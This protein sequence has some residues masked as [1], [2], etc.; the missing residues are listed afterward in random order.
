MT[1]AT[2][3]GAIAIGRNEGARLERCLDSLVGVADVV[4]YVDS[5]STDGS[6]ERAR[7]R[8]VHVVE[9]PKGT[10]FTAGR[11]RNLG[12]ET[13]RA[14]AP[15]LAFVQFVDGDCEVVPGWLG[16]AKAH[17][18][19][20]PEVAVVCG[21]RRE[22]APEATPYNRIT[23]MEWNTPIGER[24]D[25]GGDALFRAGV[26]AAAGGFD[27]NLIAGEEPELCLRIRREGHRIHRID[28]DMTLHDADLRYFG[29]WWR[30]QVRS[31]HA[32]VES[33]HLHGGSEDRFF[34]RNLVS[35]GAWALAPPALALLGVLFFGWP[36]L[37]PLGLYAV[38]AARVFRARRRLE[39]PA[40]HAAL[41][42]ASVVVGK[43]AEFQGTVTYAWNR[44]VRG[45]RTG[46]LEYKGP[47]EPSSS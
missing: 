28:R 30:R 7:A 20:H 40:G 9:L 6:R 38:L 8:G 25:C 36:G 27:P 41:Y 35:I 13:L 33:V 2:G 4:V 37:L 23:D 19:A 46:L 10:G 15:D 21:R 14:Q 1:G 22:R 16:D 29:Q 24:D 17:L 44:F 12:F 39:D 3:I 47:D 32:Y 34:V 26:F 31:G 18:E 11:A 45:R 43:W 5:G 42:A